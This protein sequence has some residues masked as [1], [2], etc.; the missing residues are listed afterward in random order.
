MRWVTALIVAMSA[1]AV[2]AQESD[3]QKH[4]KAWADQFAG[5][6]VAESVAT[7]DDGPVEEGEKY[8]AY[9][10]YEWTPN[11]EALI[12]T[13]S[14]KK[15][16][17]TFDTTKGIAGWDASNKAVV[18][19]WFDSLGRTGEFAIKKRGKNWTIK[20][21][22][23]DA[24]GQRTISNGTVKLE[25]GKQHVHMTNRKVGREERPDSDLI[26]ERKS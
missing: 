26:W 23:V 17:E 5:E 12:L 9:H 10:C 11:K 3:H 20:W 7:E 14:A 4:L 22:S 21:Q 25:D 8:T 15:D 16:G 24:E 2:Q 19:R 1:V 18:V 6:W 13:Y